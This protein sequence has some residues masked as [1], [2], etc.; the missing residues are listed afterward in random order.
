MIQFIA[1]LFKVSTILSQKPVKSN[2]DN[3]TILSS[4]FL[5]WRFIVLIEVFLSPTRQVLG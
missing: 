5:D 4:I 3:L 1:R 2:G